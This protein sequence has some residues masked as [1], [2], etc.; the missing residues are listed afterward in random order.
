MIWASGCQTSS[1]AGDNSWPSSIEHSR[2]GSHRQPSWPLLF[3]RWWNSLPLS[4]FCVFHRAAG[5]DTAMIVTVDS[6]FPLMSPDSAVFPTIRAAGADVFLA[7]HLP[8]CDDSTVVA[9]RGVVEWS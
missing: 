7:Y 9:F 3:R 6:R 5:V 2:R 8:G 4:W 1:R